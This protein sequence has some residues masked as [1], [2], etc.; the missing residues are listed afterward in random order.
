M[1]SHTWISHDHR[2]SDTDFTVGHHVKIHEI[3]LNAQNLKMGHFITGSFSDMNWRRQSGG[4]PCSLNERHCGMH[5]TNGSL[6]HS[7]FE[8]DISSDDYANMQQAGERD[9][10]FRQKKKNDHKG[11]CHVLN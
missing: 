9:V 2:H 5:K 6:H 10:Y 8:R 3:P 7:H 11:R 4:C 1:N